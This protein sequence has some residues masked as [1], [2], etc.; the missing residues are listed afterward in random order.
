MWAALASSGSA[1]AGAL[2]AA[3]QLRSLRIAGAALGSSPHCLRR[4]T[5]L[6]CLE[7][8]TARPGLAGMLSCLVQLRHLSARQLLPLV[9]CTALSR[10][11]LA[12]N[13]L[14]SIDAAAVAAGAADG[15]D[16]DSS[17]GAVVL[18]QL[19][20]ALQ[21]LQELDVSG[22]RVQLQPVYCLT[23]LTSLHAENDLGPE[24]SAVAA[25]AAAASAARMEALNS[26]VADGTAVAAVAAAVAAAAAAAAGLQHLVHMQQ[27]EQLD[28]SSCGLQD[29]TPLVHL[30]G[31]LT[32]LKLGF[33][34][35]WRHQYNKLEPAS[36]QALGHITGLRHLDLHYCRGQYTRL[37]DEASALGRLSRLTH[38]DL[39]GCWNACWQLTK[40]ACSC[41]PPSIGSI[42]DPSAATTS[43]TSSRSS[44]SWLCQLPELQ[45]LLMLLQD[46]AA[47]PKVVHSCQQLRVL[48]MSDGGQQMLGSIRSLTALQQLSGLTSLSMSSL[49]VLG[50]IAEVAQLTGLRHLKLFSSQGLQDEQALQLLSA[51]IAPTD[52]V[53]SAGKRIP[54]SSSR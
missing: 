47:L 13:N 36:F 2:A 42:T 23:R 4:L 21:Q 29:I 20:P 52:T 35:F 30:A 19:L 40:A 37:P 11:C 9:A 50:C 32:Q 33:S 41:Q 6:T 45:E 16:D 26:A 34:G 10:L 8:T 1:A 14:G 28:L 49:E 5:Q 7:L 51:N 39:S 24:A 15:D 43:T 25:A 12:S 54:Y 17:S 48:H 31:C 22:C 44:S 38:L 27:L 53:A 46:H 18:S 3:T